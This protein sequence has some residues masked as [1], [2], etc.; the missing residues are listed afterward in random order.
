M[1]END[2]RDVSLHEHLEDLAEAERLR[3]NERFEA[4][5]RHVRLE[6]DKIEQ[7][8]KL[9]ALQ[10]ERRLETL[11]HME[12]SALE[13]VDKRLAQ[14]EKWQSNLTG[15]MVGLSIIG[16]LIIAGVTA[17]LTRFLG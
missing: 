12:E 9:Q 14:L 3:I 16:A 4:E 5:R 13:R 1:T 10:Y 11:N 15:R 17:A 7:A 8:T 6:F 2:P